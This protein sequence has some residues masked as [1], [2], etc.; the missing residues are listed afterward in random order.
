M[1]AEPRT[2]QPSILILGA[3]GYIGG[4]ILV[5]IIK[6]LPQAQVSVL[7]RNSAHDGALTAAGVAHT[8]HADT[9]DSEAV[10]QLAAQFDVVVNAADAD[11]QKLLEA[12]VAGME[13][14]K[15]VKGKR[16]ILLHISGA[17]VAADESIGVWD[18]S[19]VPI[20][21]AKEAAIR[22]IPSNRAHRHVELAVFAADTAGT[23][24]GYILSPGAVFGT[25]SSPVRRDSTFLAGIYMATFGRGLQIGEGTNRSPTV[26]V[27]DL[28]DFALLVLQHALSSSSEAEGAYAKYYF[29]A[30]AEVEQ[31]ELARSVI[32]SLDTLGKD[33]DEVKIVSLAEAESL[34]PYAAALARN[35][36]VVA[37]RGKALG[38]KPKHNEP[39]LDGVHDMLAAISK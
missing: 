1:S 13:L 33:T 26:H 32:K 22:D 35:W 18:P 37:N 15:A 34:N 14:Y 30:S 4:A 20:D 8:H 2:S 25:S 31:R 16:A 39:I 24:S 9:K 23:I 36:T 6:A 27:D 5:A 11:D 7:T 17:F 21:D 19:Y 3:T 38:W 29:V 10:K 12:I 28:G